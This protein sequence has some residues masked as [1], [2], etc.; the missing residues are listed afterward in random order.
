MIE[1]L[2]PLRYVSTKIPLSDQQIGALVRENFF[3]AGVVVRMGR[4]IFINPQKLDEFLQAGGKP[5]PGGW[6]RKAD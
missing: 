6:K 2:E 5:W 3:P 1:K 4:R